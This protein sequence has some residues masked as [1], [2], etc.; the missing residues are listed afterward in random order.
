M[1]EVREIRDKSEALRAYMKQ[2]GESLVMQN[3]CAEIKLRADRRLGDMLAVMPRAE[4]GHPGPE[5]TSHDVTLNDLRISRKQ[6]SRWQA[7][8]SLLEPVGVDLGDG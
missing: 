5:K 4:K 7:V 8:A 3:Q 1:D 6:S 2:S